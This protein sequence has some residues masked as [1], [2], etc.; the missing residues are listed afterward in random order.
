MPLRLAIGWFVS[1]CLEGRGD[2]D[3]LDVRAQLGFADAVR[4]QQRQRQAAVRRL[5]EVT[6]GEV[7]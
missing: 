1:S 6:G 4:E 2:D 3:L 5:A 7:A